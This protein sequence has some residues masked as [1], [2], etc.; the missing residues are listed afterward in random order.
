MSAED[1]LNPLPLDDDDGVSGGLQKPLEGLGDDDK[2]I[3][4]NGVDDD[5]G[6]GHNDLKLRPEFDR[7]EAEAALAS[8]SLASLSLTDGH[9]VV[10]RDSF[11]VRVAGE[12]YH[13]LILLGRIQKS[14]LPDMNLDF[15]PFSLNCDQ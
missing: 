9:L 2:L 12:P 4:S 13:A 11:D 5:A 3:T 6:V 1:C 8:M 15:T 7:T 14:S 10:M